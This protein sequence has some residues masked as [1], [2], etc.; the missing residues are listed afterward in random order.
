VARSLYL[1]LSVDG[2]EDPFF[3]TVSIE[4][5]DEPIIAFRKI[6]LFDKS[7]SGQVKVKGYE[8]RPVII[9]SAPKG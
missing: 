1:E 6:G 5:F 3:L 9:K 4:G 7:L 2:F 8:E